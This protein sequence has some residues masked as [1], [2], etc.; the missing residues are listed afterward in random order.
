MRGYA[1]NKLTNLFLSDGGIRLEDSQYPAGAARRRGVITRNI[2][3]N[4]RGLNLFYSICS[5]VL[6][7]VYVYTT[8]VTTAY[9]RLPY[10]Y[11]ISHSHYM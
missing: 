1:G 6:A 11:V 2:I 9:T 10:T 5:Y 4:S 3:E 8:L 7:T